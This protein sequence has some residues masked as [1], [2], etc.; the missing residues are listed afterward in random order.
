MK[1]NERTR[2]WEIIRENT[3]QSTRMPGTGIGSESISEELEPGYY[4]AL[5]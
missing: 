1:Y 4:L 5:M 3:T 2:S